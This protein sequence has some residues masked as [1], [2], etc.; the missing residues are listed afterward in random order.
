MTSSCGSIRLCIHPSQCSF[1][2]ADS[3]LDVRSFF[4]ITII[5]MSIH[6]CIRSSFIAVFIHISDVSP[7]HSSFSVFV[8]PV[9]SCISDFIHLCIRSPPCPFVNISVCNHPASYHINF[10]VFAHFCV[11]SSMYPFICV[12]TPHR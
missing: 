1:V 9:C 10:A 8:L 6:L 2:P 11:H 3:N 4:P 12:H 7:Q 5:S